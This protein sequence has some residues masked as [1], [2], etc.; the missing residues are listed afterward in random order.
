MKTKLSAIVV[1]FFL[2]ACGS[3]DTT[4]PAEKPAEEVKPQAMKFILKGSDGNYVT[5][6]P[7]FALVAN[8]AESEKAEVFEKVDV[9]NGKCSIKASNGKFVSDDRSKYS[10]LF[11][12]RDQNGEWETF[13]IIA[14][15]QQFVNIKTSAG[16]F[17]SCDRS[18]NS[19]FY[20]DRP[21]AGDWEKFSLIKQ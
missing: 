2:M 5:I 16:K 17:V 14:L 4:S 1:L 6:A 12:N 13:E 7:D 10:Q 19:I 20:G 18:K 21:E 3:G 11:A 9:G 15:D 8:Q